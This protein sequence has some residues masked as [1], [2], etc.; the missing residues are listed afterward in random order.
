MAGRAT[1]TPTRAE[2]KIGR[3]G[4]MPTISTV[5]QGGAQRSEQYL[6]ARTGEG[7]R[8]AD[9]Q[10][11]QV[12][13]SG[14]PQ[15][16]GYAHYRCA[17]GAT[18]ASTGSPAASERSPWVERDRTARRCG[19]GA[20]ATGREW[21]K[22]SAPAGARQGRR[23]RDRRACDRERSWR[24][25]VLG[26]RIA[27]GGRERGAKPSPPAASGRSRS[28]SG[29]PERWPVTLVL[30]KPALAGVGAL[31]GV[32]ARMGRTR[33]R[34]DRGERRFPEIRSGR[35]CRV[36]SAQTPHLESLMT[37]ADPRWRH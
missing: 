12:L 11:A 6:E 19:S 21:R 33:R 34:L 27:R 28:R 10:P 2:P 20:K 36:D 4:G 35:V 3:P 25:V 7:A 17:S 16:S 32:P 8:A 23:C 29:A 1:R 14:S 18:R 15:G 31:R 5:A 37:K 26:R 9:R 22:E 13:Q 24:M 30:S